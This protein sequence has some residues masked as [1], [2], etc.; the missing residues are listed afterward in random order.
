V[1]RLA[2]LP[3]V[4][5][6]RAEQVL[7]KLEQ[8]QQSGHATQALTE[9]A[10]DLPLFA[11]MKSAP[12]GA[13]AHVPALTPEESAVLDAVKALDPDS[14]PPRAALEELYRLRGLLKGET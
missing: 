14:L 7:A 3:D 13:G 5:V 9:L 1:A 11:A 2:G 8:G 6:A 12:R 4:A 10:E